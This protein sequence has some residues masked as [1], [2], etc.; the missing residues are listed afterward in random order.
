MLTRIPLKPLFLLLVLLMASAAA[1]LNAKDLAR[2]KMVTG[3][4]VSPDG[5]KVAYLLRVQRALEDDDFEDGGA[6]SELHVFANGRSRPYISGEVSI[7]SL[8]WSPDSQEIFYL[9]KRRDDKQTSLYAIPF[10]GGESVKALEFEAGIAGFSLSPDGQRV[11]FLAKEPKAESVE[12]REKKGFNQQVVE[13][14]WAETRVYVA[15]RGQ[16]TKDLEPLPLDGSASE[17]SWSP[18]RGD[19]RLVVA[20]APDPGVDAFYMYRR[21]RVIDS[22]GKVLAKIANPGK[23]GQVEWSPNGAKVAFVS[24]L[25]INDPREGHLM[26]ADATSGKIEDLT[27]NLPGH[28]G[29]FAWTSNE[30]LEAL[31]SYGT[32]I[33][34]VR[35]ST[36]GRLQRLQTD[37][38]V[39]RHLSHGGGKTAYL[40]DSPA[41]PPELF[42]GQTRV[43]RSNPWLSSKKL[44]RQEVVSYQARDGLELEGIAIFPLEKSTGP[45]PMVL[46]VHGGPEAHYS[47]GWNSHYSTP[48]Q[49]LAAQGY[50]VFYPNYRGSTGRG[51]EFS[52][53]SQADPAGKEFD[54]LVDAVDHFVNQGLVDKSK[55]GIT[56]GSYGGYASA[57]G[58]TYYSERFAAS[59]MFVGISDKISKVGTT[60]IPDEEYL[61]HARKRPWDN[62]EFFLKRSP[63]NYVK[64]ARTPI[65]IMHGKEDPRVHPTQS[66][67]LFRFLKVIGETPVRLVFFQGEGHGNR[68][69][70]ARYDYS[71]RLLRWMNHYL[72]G[73]G[74]DPPA[75]EIDYDLEGI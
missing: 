5:Q 46:I 50:L 14:D 30:S 20:L 70:A 35:V 52:K 64:K 39:Y 38:I 22:T 75:Y 43:T 71:L 7:S 29:H 3:V 1:Q 19:S 17:M 37:D 47:N 33:D 15:R 63:I 40:A 13:E 65:L 51:L 31:I 25:D 66:M 23:L 16:K 6:F 69:A 8:Q 58:A 57:W 55:V 18:A 9:A 56:G 67:E 32:D 34:R 28:V 12:K 53:T 72:K 41:H 68:K 59:V 60:D 4:A 49:V 62:F 74:G 48:G 11:A 45:G 26:V 36:G 21:L 10:A 54:D 73:P 61:V 44:A 27:K 42:V 2:L 24:G